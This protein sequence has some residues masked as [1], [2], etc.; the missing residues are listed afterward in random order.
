MSPEIHGAIVSGAIG[1]VVVVTGVVL[2]EAA[3]GLRERRRV[4]E[5]AA[6][7]IANLVPHVVSAMWDGW[8]KDD[9]FSLS[10]RE[11]QERNERVTHLT[12]EIQIRAR[13]PIRNAREVRRHVHRLTVRLAAADLRWLSS[14]KTLT[15]EDRDHMSVVVADVN[16]AIFRSRIGPP[17]DREVEHHLVHGNEIDFEKCAECAAVMRSTLGRGGVTGR[18]PK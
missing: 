9:P 1:G 17:L 3:I 4:V 10:P 14:G 8:A 2:A 13:W 16:R 18:L 11:W 5:K 15:S 12:A 6:L 7:E